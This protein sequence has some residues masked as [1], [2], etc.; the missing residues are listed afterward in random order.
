MDGKIKPCK[1][2]GEE[3]YGIWSSGRNQ[4][5]WYYLWCEECGYQSEY[6]ETKEE[7]IEAWNKP[8]GEN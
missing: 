1:K 5:D 4:T 2:C 7:A 8:E 3:N 6:C